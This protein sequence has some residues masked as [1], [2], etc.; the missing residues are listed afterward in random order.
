M[1]SVN[2]VLRH[3]Q[4]EQSDMWDMLTTCVQSWRGSL[5]LVSLLLSTTAP[6]PRPGQPLLQGGV[7]GVR[8]ALLGAGPA[9]SPVR[10]SAEVGPWR[11][12]MIVV[13][14]DTESAWRAALHSLTFLSG[15]GPRAGV[16]AREHQHDHKDLKALSLTSLPALSLLALALLT[17]GQIKTL[18]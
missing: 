5:G 4:S 16:V 12:L 7:P 8:S 13:V 14:V 9:V 17:R 18:M 11:C 2:I 10:C 3:W 6:A 15:L 1:L